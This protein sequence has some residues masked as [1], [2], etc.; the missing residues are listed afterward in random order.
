MFDCAA[1]A[2]FYEAYLASHEG[3]L[4][5][6]TTAKINDRGEW[7]YP[8]NRAG[9]ADEVRTWLRG[10][11]SKG[12]DAHLSLGLIPEELVGDDSKFEQKHVR[13]Q[14]AV[15]RFFAFDFDIYH[16]GR[17]KPSDYDSGDE[18]EEALAAA[19]DA[20]MPDPDFVVRTGSGGVHY[21][22]FATNY[23]GG[24]SHKRVYEA[25]TERMA[26]YG[27]RLD[28]QAGSIRKRLRAP[29]STNNKPHVRA[30]VSCE[31]RV[32]KIRR[33]KAL[34]AAFDISVRATLADAKEIA[35][36]HAE[37]HD[38]PEY[39]IYTSDVVKE[40]C[41]Y[42][43]Y[44]LASGSADLNRE[45][46]LGVATIVRH[47]KGWPAAWSQACKDHYGDVTDAQLATALDPEE[48]LRGP[49]SCA[50]IGGGP[51]AH[52]ACK[53]CLAH[54]MP[55]GGGYPINWIQAVDKAANDGRTMATR[56]TP[57][58]A[59]P[60]QPPEAR[61][62]PYGDVAMSGFMVSPCTD[63]HGV[64]TAQTHRGKDVPKALILQPA[65]SVTRME[66]R[67]A[68][69][70][71]FL[72][73]KGT[74]RSMEMG[75]V[76]NK[77]TLAKALGTVGVTVLDAAATQRYMHGVI[78]ENRIPTVN[79]GQSAGW[80]SDFRAFTTLTDT[81]RVGGQRTPSQL[82]NPPLNGATAGMG[83]SLESWQAALE[84]VKQYDAQL[85]IFGVMLGFASIL[86]KLITSTEPP[87]ATVSIYH[88]DSGRGKSTVLRMGNSVFM[89]PVE[90]SIGFD[91]TA[92]STYKSMGVLN[93][94][95]CSIDEMTARVSD[96]N[97]DANQFVS[98]ASSGVERGRLTSSS[99]QM[100]RSG[101]KCILAVSTNA[102]INEVLAREDA[103]GGFARLHEIHVSKIPMPKYE[104]DQ[105]L[106][107]LSLSHGVAGPAFV[108]R[109]LDTD[110]MRGYVRGVFDRWQASLGAAV[111]VGNPERFAVNL[112]AYVMSAAEMVMQYDILE[113][114]TKALFD[115]CVQE[116]ESR[117]KAV[118]VQIQR[119]E[120]MPSDLFNHFRN[121]IFNVRGYRLY[122]TESGLLRESNYPIFYE[123]GVLYV[124]NAAIVEFCTQYRTRRTL[125]TGWANR[126]L[127][128]HEV[129]ERGF[130]MMDQ[131]IAS[132]K[133]HQFYLSKFIDKDGLAEIEALSQVRADVA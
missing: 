51:D 95:F 86:P 30:A 72:D 104:A 56:A 131:R 44:Q 4:F 48:G 75:S 80:S 81:Y 55:R 2:A 96:P 127:V 20:G 107:N 110:D 31:Q 38:L 8:K 32:P 34:Q 63:G 41:P 124:T 74:E 25:L 121:D 89:Q 14:N 83:G 26:G 92:A 84:P 123:D 6:L 15:T 133:Y 19:H 1:T 7:T 70:M 46:W 47:L 130:K 61:M 3:F 42:M 102:S 17:R 77:N 79:M 35:Q 126:G 18:I 88:P 68:G 10:A 11:I 73:V 118:Q 69:S 91:D 103:M 36:A 106:A 129:V 52:S 13:H 76:N 23:V 53:G 114:D 99:T 24:L 120:V 98:V 87:P 62:K 111:S 49:I 50:A 65:F 113:V 66:Q 108:Q 43:V 5:G 29:G 125:V 115:W 9:T 28:P 128:S 109:L 37:D 57:P 67:N 45:Q 100:A 78:T 119:A 93:N 132:Q 122:E 39:G 16:D 82:E 71:I 60:E 94:L 12:F 97:F 112:F 117:M 64:F 27:L 58:T 33:M 22:Y 59:T 40:A 105:V 85:L 54:T 116:L 21:W 90:S 101:W